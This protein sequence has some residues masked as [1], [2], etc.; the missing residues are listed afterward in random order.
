MNNEQKVAQFLAQFYG[1]PAD[2]PLDQ[3]DLDELVFDLV[4]EQKS[5]NLNCLE[6]DSEEFENA[7]CDLEAQAARINNEGREAQVDFVSEMID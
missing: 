7:L 3:N 6:G 5:S 4:F 1:R 2:T